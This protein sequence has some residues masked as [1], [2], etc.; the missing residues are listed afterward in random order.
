MVTVRRVEHIAQMTRALIAK[1][2]VAL[3]ARWE[4]CEETGLALMSPGICR[5]G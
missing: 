4:R 3:H 1:T 2:R 5:D